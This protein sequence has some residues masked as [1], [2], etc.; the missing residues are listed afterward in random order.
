MALCATLRS[1]GNFRV[2][3]GLLADLL[4]LRLPT[5]VR[6]DLRPFKTAAPRPVTAETPDSPDANFESGV[7]DRP[8][9]AKGDDFTTVGLLGTETGETVS[10]A[11]GG[12]ALALTGRAI[13][14]RVGESGLLLGFTC[15]GDVG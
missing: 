2:G 6:G 15:L 10:D 5:L 13:T 1:C 3:L 14:G 11:S 9:L 8:R 4:R 12:F 7:F